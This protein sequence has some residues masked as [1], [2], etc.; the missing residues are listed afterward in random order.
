M[1][2]CEAEDGRG[3]INEVY[4]LIA[5]T[6]GGDY[7]RCADDEGNPEA[8]IVRPAFASWQA[9]AVVA[10]E[11]NDGFV[12]EA[13]GIEFF[14]DITYLF[15]HCSDVVIVFCKVAPDDGGVG[16]V[17]GDLYPCGIV[18]SFF[19]VPAFAF[20]GHGEIDDGEKGCIFGAVLIA[21]VSASGVPC[22]EGRAKLV[23]GLGVIRAVVS[24]YSEVLGETSDVRGRYTFVTSQR[25][26]HV[27]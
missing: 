6:A 26:A 14:K 18:D 9:S 12:G 24:S 19:D 27:H 10:P 22:C 1:N 5:D 13:V 11:E 23:I 16:I 21:P 3:K 17:R 20:M 25:G 7:L 8:G 4:E 2:A 15:V